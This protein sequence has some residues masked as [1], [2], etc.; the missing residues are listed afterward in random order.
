MADN[1][2][3]DVMQLWQLHNAEQLILDDFEINPENY[4]DK[5]LK[6]LSDDE[7]FDEENSIEYTQAYHKKQLLPKMI[8]VSVFPKF[9]FFLLDLNA[10]N[11]LVP[12]TLF[13]SFINH[14]PEISCFL[15]PESKCER[16]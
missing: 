7:E 14:L 3:I 1:I 5:N 13:S 9:S 11:F 16:T 8:V 10:R 12:S 4:K 6:D 15:L 2:D